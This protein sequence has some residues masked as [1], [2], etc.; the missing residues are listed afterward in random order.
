MFLLR[1]RLQHQWFT[2]TADFAPVGSVFFLVLM[3]LLLQSHLAPVPGVPVE[4]A[5]VESDLPAF[6]PD[7]Q[8][9]VVDREGRLFYRQQ[10]ITDAALVRQLSDFTT[11]SSDQA[12]LVIQADRS[13]RLERLAEVYALCRQAGITRLKLQTRPAVG[14][15]V[16][17]HRRP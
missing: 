9:V 6:G 15:P 16:S 4:L 2:G 7:C 12:L 11:R 3:F 17:L 5:M 10:L 14:Q 1:N 8:V 13:L